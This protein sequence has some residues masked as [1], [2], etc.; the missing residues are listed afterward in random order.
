[1]R[2]SVD[3]WRE[4]GCSFRWIFLSLEIQLNIFEFNSYDYLYRII[5][6]IICIW[7]YVISNDWNEEN[8]ENGEKNGCYWYIEKCE[9][10]SAAKS[11]ELQI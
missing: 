1:M 5:Y 8:G 2:F 4:I 11:S 10:L 9:S 7:M 6:A 3:R